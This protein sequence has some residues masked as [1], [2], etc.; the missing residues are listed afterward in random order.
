MNKQSL[1]YQVLEELRDIVNDAIHPHKGYY[2]SLFFFWLA[3]RRVQW[4]FSHRPHPFA[5]L[6]FVL[7]LLFYLLKG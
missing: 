4:E 3:K 1:T 5:L 6:L 7:A 2:E